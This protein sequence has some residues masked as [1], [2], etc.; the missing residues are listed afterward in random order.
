MK[1]IIRLL[2]ATS[3][4]VL[5]SSCE[6]PTK[7]NSVD[8]ITVSSYNKIMSNDMDTI[9]VSEEFDNVYVIEDDVVQYK[10]KVVNDNSMQFPIGIFIF[11]LI[12]VF[13]LGGIV[14]DII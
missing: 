7:E 3:V 4:M 1:K 8:G 11:I 9:V 13:L 14:W 10:M 12:G 6:S 5:A 2:L